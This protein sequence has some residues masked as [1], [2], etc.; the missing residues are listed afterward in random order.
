MADCLVRLIE[1][2]TS[3]YSNYYYS[4]RVKRGD[5]RG[6]RKRKQIFFLLSVLCGWGARKRPLL[7]RRGLG[8]DLEM[9]DGGAVT[10]SSR[11]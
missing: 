10:C 8:T 1:S 11:M 4:G 3:Y 7:C 2:A 5:G 9:E 6:A